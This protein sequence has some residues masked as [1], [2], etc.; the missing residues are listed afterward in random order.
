MFKSLALEPRNPLVPPLF[1]G[2]ALRQLILL[3]SVTVLA[4]QTLATAQSSNTSGLEAYAKAIKQSNIA[5]RIAAME[6]FLTIADSGSLRLD[7]LEVLSWDYRQ[8]GNPSKSSSTAEELLKMDQSNPIALA[9]LSEDQRKTALASQNV[10]DE[11]YNMATRGL[12]G[13]A[14]LRKPEGMLPANFSLMQR[15]ITGMLNGMAGLG[16][17]DHSDYDNARDHLKNAVNVE[18]NN[19]RYI[20]GLAL[21]LLLAK[22]PDQQDGYWYLAR[23][24][25]LT[26]GTPSGV[27]VAQYARSRYRSAGGSDANWNQ[28]LAAT[29]VPRS[30]QPAAVQAANAPAPSSPATTASNASP[31][32]SPATSTSAPSSAATS[33]P[34]I[35]ASTSSSTPPSASSPAR[36]ATASP[37]ASAPA[38]A[39]P[40][41]TS[42]AAATT[43]TASRNTPVNIGPPPLAGA[44]SSEHPELNPPPQQA[45]A[46]PA[47]RKPGG[48]SAPNAPISLGILLQTSLLSGGN[49][50][51]IIAALTEMVQRLRPEDEAFIMAFSS[52]LDFEQDLTANDQLLLDAMAE[53]KPKSGAALL[54]GVEFAAGHLKRIGKNPN[55]VLLIISDGRNSSNKAG[56]TL[57]AQ[58]KDVRVD[59]IGIDVGGEAERALLQRLAASSGGHA[60][61]TDN[62]QQFR[63]AASQMTDLLGI[64]NH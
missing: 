45:A 51:E 18:P 24:V 32:A 60:S 57:S 64:E 53:L 17:L 44:R 37:S 1:S 38:A 7:A 14:R 63:A 40:P 52:Q 43:T 16:Y 19:S 28:Y 50:P 36:S 48:M 5:D 23:A 49:R 27:Q 29:A 42:P 25:N 33:S 34:S 10:S 46:R 12:S 3:I 35:A 22:N 47:T 39:A 62:P 30:S 59:C 11:Q 61:F 8:M 13:L 20:Y 54:E 41:A 15:Q 55:R 6:Q 26:Q 21:A 2:K 56:S 58:L 4:F 9:I 31:A